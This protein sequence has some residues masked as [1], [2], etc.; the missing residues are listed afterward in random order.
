MQALVQ[1]LKVSQISKNYKTSITLLKSKMSSDG[2]SPN[3]TAKL[4]KSGDKRDRT[5]TNLRKADVFLLD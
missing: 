1:N 5:A 2:S 3:P 4:I